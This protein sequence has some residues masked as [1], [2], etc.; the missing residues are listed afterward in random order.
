M[1]RMEPKFK[2]KP[3]WSED[4][5][6]LLIQLIGERRGIIKA[7]FS[8]SLTWADKR[9]AWEDIASDINAAFPMVRRAPEECEKKWYSVQSNAEQEITAKKRE[10]QGTGE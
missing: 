1:K 8:A 2:R 3:N 6:V 5:V 7:K 9:K 10:L 4:Q